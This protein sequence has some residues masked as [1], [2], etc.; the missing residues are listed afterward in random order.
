MEVENAFVNRREN[1][2]A[3]T[4]DVAKVLFSSNKVVFLSFIR[5]KNTR[6]KN[7]NP[8]HSALTERTLNNNEKPSP[9]R[10]L[11]HTQISPP[12]SLLTLY[13]H[14]LIREPSIKHK[15]INTL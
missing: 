1:Q 13:T 9:L 2:E 12:A 14:N 5:S 7:L 11:R 15:E 4:L 6:D 10:Y 3:I 8:Q